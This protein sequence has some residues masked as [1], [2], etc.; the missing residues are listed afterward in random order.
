VQRRDPRSH[1]AAFQR[2]LAT[3]RQLLARTL[4]S[5]DQVVAGRDVRVARYR[6]GAVEVVVNLG[7]GPALV[8][9]PAPAVFDSDD[10]DVQVEKPRAG[11]AALAAQQALVLLHS[12]P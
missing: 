8:D 5:S 11:I 10:P 3:R 4:S 2:L 12:E 7:D 9:L 6:R 1:L